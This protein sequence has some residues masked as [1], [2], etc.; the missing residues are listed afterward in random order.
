[1]EWV[2]IE[3][4]PLQGPRRICFVQYTSVYISSQYAN[5]NPYNKRKTC[6]S[7]V[8]TSC[9]LINLGTRA[10][11]SRKLSKHERLLVPLPPSKCH[12]WDISSACS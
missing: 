9:H 4:Q 7:G 6:N 3:L 1:M 2:Y 5:K 11:R 10:Q 12:F 8:T